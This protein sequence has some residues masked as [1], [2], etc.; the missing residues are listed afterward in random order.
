MDTNTSRLEAHPDFYRLLM[1]G[2]FDA[3]VLKPFENSLASKWQGLKYFRFSA[4]LF[5][6]IDDSK[7]KVL[8]F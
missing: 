5:N 1:K 7:F 2:E 3:Y 4:V 6:E 8:V